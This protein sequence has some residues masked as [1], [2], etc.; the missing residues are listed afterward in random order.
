MPVKFNLTKPYWLML[1]SEP[2]Y[3]TR[4]WQKKTGESTQPA[5]SDSVLYDKQQ[6]AIT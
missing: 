3:W 6:P 1:F 4:F 5:K 2:T